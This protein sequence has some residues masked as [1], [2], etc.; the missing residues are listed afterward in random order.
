MVSPRAALA[1]LGILT[2]SMMMAGG[3]AARG[4][5]RAIVDAAAAPSSNGALAAVAA[6]PH[7][8]DVWVVGS[9]A[10]SPDGEHYFEARRHHGRWQRFKS[11]NVGGRFGSLTAVA[12]GS[13]NSVWVAGE[14]TVHRSK[15]LPVVFRLAGKRFVP[16]KLPRLKLLES[17]AGGVAALSASSPGNAWAVGTIIDAATD[18]SVALHWNGRK[19]SAVPL[20]RPSGDDGLIGVSTTGPNNAWAVSPEG[21]LIHW[22]GKTWTNAGTA[23]ARVQ[24]EAIA[25]GS[26]TNA[27]AVGY[28]LLP[29]SRYRAVIMR[30]NGATWSMAKMASGAG[31]TQLLSVA[32]HGTSAWAIG[33]RTTAQGVELPAFVHSTG[34]AWKAQHAPGRTVTVS[35]VA[36]E[37]AKRAYVAGYHY[38]ARGAVKSFLDVNNGHAWKPAASNF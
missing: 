29:R 35:A 2:L 32:T 25:T 1:S 12:A 20:P 19:W 26:A 34:G 33:T 16:A 28:R 21:A 9:V 7:S 36:A 4:A 27:Y 30:F 15:E 23:P 18:K 31:N 11:P 14:K 13:A 5:P 17:G 37:S 24:L 10:A 6:V 22:N 3:T 38:T 8:S